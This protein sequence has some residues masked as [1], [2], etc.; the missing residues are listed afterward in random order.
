[1][2]NINLGMHPAIGTYWK[3][4]YPYDN[5]MCLIVGMLSVLEKDDVPLVIYI[6]DGKCYLDRSSVSIDSW[7]NGQTKWKQL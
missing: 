4:I 3:S 2:S 7:I 1:M 5:S 6:I